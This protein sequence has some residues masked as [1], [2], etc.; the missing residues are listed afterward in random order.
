MSLLRLWHILTLPP[1]FFLLSFSQMS[2]FEMLTSFDG[3]EDGAN[4]W[5]DKVE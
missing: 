3:A 5:Q 4:Y 1:A 2:R